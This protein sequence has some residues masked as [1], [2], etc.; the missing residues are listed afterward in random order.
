MIL[1]RETIV[2]VFLILIAISY[3]IGLWIGPSLASNRYN[4]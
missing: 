1:K 3:L 2:K 4:Y